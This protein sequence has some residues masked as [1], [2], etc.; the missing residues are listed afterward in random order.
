[1]C[2]LSDNCKPIQTWKKACYKSGASATC[3]YK[4]SS[5][6]QGTAFYYAVYATKSCRAISCVSVELV[7]DVSGDCLRHQ[8]SMWWV[9]SQTSDTNFTWTRFIAREDT[10]VWPFHESFSS[11]IYEY[12]LL[13]IFSLILGYII[14]SPVTVAERSKTYTVFARSEAGILGSN[15]TQ[16]MDFWY[17]FILCLSCRVFR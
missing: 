11:H 9:F 16:D 13:N 7:S 10:I 17:V 4:C 1:V 5:Q 2:H 6:Q 8:C 3:E 14:P 12:N 15:P